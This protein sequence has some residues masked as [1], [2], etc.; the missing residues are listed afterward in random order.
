MNNKVNSP[1]DKPVNNLNSPPKPLPF[2]DDL[3]N[4]LRWHNQKSK[5]TYL[6]VKILLAFL[7]SSTAS[8]QAED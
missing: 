2:A 5:A 3:L 8:P 6:D 7:A 4:K 1:S